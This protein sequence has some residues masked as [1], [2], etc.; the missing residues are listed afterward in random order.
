MQNSELPVMHVQDLRAVAFDAFG[1]LV[2]IAAPR[3]PYKKLL[4][5]LVQH[6]SSDA[7]LL[8]RRMMTENLPFAEMISLLVPF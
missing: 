3:R 1:T 6:Q 7:A 4:Q 8:G 5:W 2:Q